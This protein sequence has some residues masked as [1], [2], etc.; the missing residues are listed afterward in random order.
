[1]DSFKRSC[2]GGM[3]DAN[4]VV[5]HDR[6]AKLL[7]IVAIPELVFIFVPFLVCGQWV[8]EP[9]FRLDN[10]LH[11]RLQPRDAIGDRAEDG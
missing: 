9:R 4:T 10:R 6:K 7:T 2:Y 8:F 11:E 5:P 3:W 1:M